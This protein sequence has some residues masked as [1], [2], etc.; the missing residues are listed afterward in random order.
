LL[1]ITILIIC[2]FFLGYIDVDKS[3]IIEDTD[4]LDPDINSTYF[5]GIIVECFALLQKVPDSI[6]TI[7][8][9]MQS[10]L[11]TIVSNTTHHLLLSYNAIAMDENASVGNSSPKLLEL[12][13]LLFKQFKL[14]ADAHTLTIK[15]FTNVI[16]RNSL[17]LKPYDI[18]DFWN[19]VQSVYQLVLTDYL[20]IQNANVDDQMRTGGT[21]NA[22]PEQTLN[23]NTFFNR[24]KLQS[25]KTLFKFDKSSH[26]QTN[27]PEEVIT[28]TV[29]KEHRRNLSNVS[30]SKEDAVGVGGVVQHLKILSLPVDSKKM[31]REKVLVCVPDQNLVR[32][33]Y[34]PMM[35]YV[36]EIEQ[37][38]KAKM[39]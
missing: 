18:S 37:L 25:K 32:A 35:N 24:R 31:K 10:E 14:I 8:V 29:V 33:V 21:A 3:E 4:L 6:E 13:E 20:D 34:L 7:K 9:Q 22:F 19:Q 12:L 5:I 2:S 15:N 23:V 28:T 36:Q 27:Q 26:S 39:G 16:K 17:Q 38:M 1:T 11:L 30:V